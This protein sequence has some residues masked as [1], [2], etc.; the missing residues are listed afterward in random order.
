MPRVVIVGGGFAGV[1][2]ARG[3]E[4][5]GRNEQLEITLVNRHNFMLFTPMLP[6]AATGSIEIRHIVQPLRVALGHGKGTGISSNFELGDATGIDI[7]RRTVAIRHPLTHDVKAIAYDELVLALGA[8]DSTMGIPGVEKYTVPLKTVADAE[9]LRDR[10]VGA[11]EIAAGTS[12]LVERDRLLRFVVI[13]GNFTGVELSGELLAF[14]RSIRRYYP[15]FDRLQ[16]ELVLVESS[17]KLLGHLPP[18]FGKY[19]ASTLVERGARLLV[20]RAVSAVDAHGVELEGG[21]RIS[22]ATVVWAAGE[23][24]A[25]LAKHLGVNTNEHGAIETGADFAVDG[26]PHVWALGDCAAIPQPGGGTYA[27]LAQNAIREGELLAS[28]IR[29]RLRGKPTKN[30]RYRE[31]GRMASLGDRQAVAEL[32][33]G[34]ML[35]GGLAWMAWRTYYLGQLPGMNQKTRVALDWTLAMAFPPEIARLPLLDQD[36]TSFEGHHAARR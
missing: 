34:R 9:V 24:P 23:E 1:S 18:K 14:L 8:T 6:E 36:T 26:A 21:E 35:T 2:T 30:F 32:P 4:R 22:S 3:L 27:P 16:V 7:A 5:A 19:A 28:N 15:R 13:G 29:A 10:I 31:F 12:D 25:P 17:D 20:G 11:L 33:G